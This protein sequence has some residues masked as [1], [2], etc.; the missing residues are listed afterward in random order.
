MN[1]YFR[2]TAYNKENDFSVILDSN[3][4]FEQLWQFGQYLTQKGFEIIETSKEMNMLDINIIKAEFDKEHIFAR[5]TADG[6]PQN[7]NQTTD[8]IT[9]K[10][11]KVADK[12]YIPDVTQRI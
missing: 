12:I 5:A 10:A 2:I 3:G 4:M 6:R 9:Y 1:N 11:I 7:I 8:G